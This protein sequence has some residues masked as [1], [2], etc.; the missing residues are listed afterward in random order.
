MRESSL[1]QDAFI[2]SC[3]VTFSGGTSCSRKSI[4][5]KGIGSSAIVGNVLAARKAGVPA[6]LCVFVV[7][8]L[9]TLRNRVHVED[10]S[11]VVR[12]EQ[13]NSSSSFHN[14]VGHTRVSVA[15][16]EGHFEI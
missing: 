16:R 14:L 11:R 2:E 6:G 9:P 12:L 5:Q 4:C 1:Q 3:K 7:C 10:E 13:R 8:V 15:I